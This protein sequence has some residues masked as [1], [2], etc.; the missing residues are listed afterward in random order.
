VHKDTR[1]TKNKCISVEKDQTS[2]GVEKSA[3]NNR[4]KKNCI[5]SVNNKVKKAQEA[6]K[7]SLNYAGTP[8]PLVNR[9]VN[10]SSRPVIGYVVEGGFSYAIGGGLALG[11]VSIQ[12]LLALLDAQK[13]SKRV[14][15]LVRSTNSVQ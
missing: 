10:T 3:G 8:I 5:K 12:G 14:E 2:K 13:G 9:V 1:N 11:F 4:D 6:I 7:A 15:V